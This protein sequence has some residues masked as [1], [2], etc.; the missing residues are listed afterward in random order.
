MSMEGKFGKPVTVP[1]ADDYLAI[2]AHSVL[3]TSTSFSL[4]FTFLSDKEILGVYAS[5]LLQ[6]PNPS[7]Y[8]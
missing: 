6:V 1:S 2:L 8:E 4:T 3:S 7:P 5:P